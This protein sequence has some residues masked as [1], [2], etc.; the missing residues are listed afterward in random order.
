MADGKSSE[1]E[2]DEDFDDAAEENEP[3][4]CN[5]RLCTCF[6]GHDQF[7]GSDDIGGDDETWTN[8]LQDLDGP[9]WRISDFRGDA[10]IV[11]LRFGGY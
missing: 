3:E 8:V 7:T 1:F 6:C 9:A 4:Q 2:L 11:E 5:A 10:T